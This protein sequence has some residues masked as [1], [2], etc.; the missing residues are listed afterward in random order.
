MINKVEI[1]NEVTLIEIIEDSIKKL[2]DK[3]KN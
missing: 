1:D 3:L 2:C